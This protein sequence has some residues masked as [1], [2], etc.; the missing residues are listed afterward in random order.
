MKIDEAFIMSTAYKQIK[1]VLDC[2]WDCM[3]DNKSD[4]IIRVGSLM[5]INGIVM[6]ADALRMSLHC[7]GS[8]SENVLNKREGDVNAD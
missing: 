5:E 8:Q 7:S 4:D 3:N 6:M 1:E 2:V